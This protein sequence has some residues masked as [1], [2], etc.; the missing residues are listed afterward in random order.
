M[1]ARGKELRPLMA[2]SHKEL[3]DRLVELLMTGE[4]DMGDV[5][6][7]EQMVEAY[8]CYR[9]LGFHKSKRYHVQL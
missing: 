2:G 8:D 1:I 6:D 3:L 4:G 7:L 9:Q 5:R